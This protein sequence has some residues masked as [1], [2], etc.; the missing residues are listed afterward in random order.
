MIG[1]QIANPMPMPWDFVVKNA[2]KLRS[3]FFGSIPCSTPAVRRPEIIGR[4]AIEV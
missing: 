4:R 3:V 1:R 2:S